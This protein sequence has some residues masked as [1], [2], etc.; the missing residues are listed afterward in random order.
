MT[1]D[2]GLLPQKFV[3]FIVNTE[4]VGTYMFRGDHKPDL[5]QEDKMPEAIGQLVERIYQVLL[6][7][8]LGDVFHII[9]APEKAPRKGTTIKVLGPSDVLDLMDKFAA[10]LAH[11]AKATQ[12]S[13]KEA[14]VKF[15]V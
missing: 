4:H 3:E 1:R 12:A 7:K 8:V 11:E 10:T 13:A 5:V 6:D 15:S 9:I 2:P 14:P